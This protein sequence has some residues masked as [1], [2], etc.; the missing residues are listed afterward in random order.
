MDY[1]Y[2]YGALKAWADANPEFSN[3]QVAI[4]LGFTDVSSFRRW[5]FGESAI[6]IEHLLKFCNLYQ[7]PL[8]WFFFDNDVIPEMHIRA[9]GINDQTE[10]TGGYTQ[11]NKKGGP[12]R[13][14]PIVSERI[15]SHVPGM[16]TRTDGDS[17]V[18]TDERNDGDTEVR[19]DGT[20]DLRNN[21]DVDITQLFISYQKAL[22][23]IQRDHIKREDEIREKYETK[24][25]KE[26]DELMT[27]I[28]SQ[29]AEIDKMKRRD[30]RWGMVGEEEEPH[31]NPPRRR[32]DI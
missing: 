7:V 19:K 6:P 21:K 13:T 20:A 12:H 30:Y 10:P 5:L 3:R 16:E 14:S 8:E 1:R 18:R 17:E 15:Y 2:N 11:R 31:P 4:K 24:W 23:D 25:D 29:R 32:G 28:R 9:A 26:R 27:I 22:Q